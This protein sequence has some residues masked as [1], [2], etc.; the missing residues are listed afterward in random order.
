MMRSLLLLL[1]QRLATFLQD[2]RG[3]SAIEFAMV[4]PLMLTLWLGTSEVSQAVGVDRK[5]TLSARAVADL[6]AQVPSVNNSGMNDVLAASGA[7]LAPFPLNNAKI[8]VSQIFIDGNGVAKITWSDTKN[9][10]ARAVGSVATVPTALKINNTYLIWGEAEY[11]YT[12]SFGS[13]IV[14][15]LTLKDQIYMRPR[16]SESV[17]RTAS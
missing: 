5:V 4:M 9:G 12:P 11:S 14:G 7:V 15:T 6:V 3:V 17:T 8:T 13:T 16:L 1:P 2:R 10:T